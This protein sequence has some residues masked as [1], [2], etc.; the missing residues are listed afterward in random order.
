MGKTY[1]AEEMCA[2]ARFYYLRIEYSYDIAE[3]AEAIANEG[4]IAFTS[5]LKMLE[6]FDAR[7]K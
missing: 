5:V 7:G 6:E 3:A 4:E 2:F 1:T